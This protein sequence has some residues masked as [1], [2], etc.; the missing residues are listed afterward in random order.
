[1]SYLVFIGIKNRFKTS[2]RICLFSYSQRNG[3][4][5]ARICLFLLNKD[6]C[7]SLRWCKGKT[8][9]KHYPR[10]ASVT[11]TKDDLVMWTSGL[12]ATATAQSTKHLGIIQESVTSGDANF[13]TSAV[14][15]CVEVPA[16]VTAEFEADVTGTL[17]TTDLEGQFDMSTAGLVNRSGTTYKVVTCVGYISATKG[18][19]TLNSNLQYA[20]PSWE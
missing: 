9:L 5:G 6:K 11:F 13:A 2:L 10:T 3:K 18:R 15:V 1:M 12:V 17:L 7:M 16:E 14:N 19:F 8:L 20:D 4:F